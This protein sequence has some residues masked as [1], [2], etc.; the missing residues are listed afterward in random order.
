MDNA[1]HAAFETL[2]LI[3]LRLME[4]ARRWDA[5]TGREVAMGILKAIHEARGD[6]P[7][8]VDRA[9]NRP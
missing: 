9:V 8:E 1:G 6:D 3:E 2:K 7:K 5:P 4:L